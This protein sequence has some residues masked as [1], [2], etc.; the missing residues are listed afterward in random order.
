MGFFMLAH[1]AY[2]AAFLV[3]GGSRASSA[4]RWPPA[5]QATRGD[6]LRGRGAEARPGGLRGI[7]S[8]MGAGAVD[9][10]L[11]A[12]RAAI[13]EIDRAL[14]EHLA[15]RRTATDAL[16]A[17]KRAAGLPA[18]DPGR[19]AELHDRW[20]AAARACGLP[21]DAAI[22]VLDAILAVSR[23]RMQSLVPEE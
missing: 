23:R 7:R 5:G 13:D 16:A 15:R 4:S 19:E 6:P 17:H 1:I 2:S 3:G 8:V 14:V 22:A 9:D 10:Q 12:L 18:L 11:S 21:D 20:R